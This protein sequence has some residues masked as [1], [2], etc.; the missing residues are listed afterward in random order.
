MLKYYFNIILAYATFIQ[1][2][3]VNSTLD[4][5]NLEIQFSPIIMDETYYYSIYP[6]YNETF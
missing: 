4:E 5:I 1:V 6:V 2:N 3:A